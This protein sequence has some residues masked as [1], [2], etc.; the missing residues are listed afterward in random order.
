M[1]HSLSLSDFSQQ[2]FTDGGY[3][4]GVAVS[5]PECE[6]RGDRHSV[7]L[8]TGFFPRPKP[9]RLIYCPLFTDFPGLPSGA[10]DTVIF[11]DQSETQVFPLGHAW[12]TH[13]MPLLSPLSTSISSLILLDY[14]ASQIIAVSSVCASASLLCMT[15]CFHAVL[16]RKFDGECQ[17]AL[18]SSPLQF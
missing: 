15:A 11:P 10:S 7:H 8:H 17:R 5:W 2:A 6:R 14:T 9:Y 12:L 16:L 1:C 18:F 13:C 4:P 3:G